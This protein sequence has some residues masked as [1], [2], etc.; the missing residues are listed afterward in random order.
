MKAV[1]F[2][3]TGD[4]RCDNIPIPCVGDDDVLIKV[5]YAGIC[6]SDKHIF[7]KGMFVEHIP[8]TMGHEFV[9]KVEKIGRNVTDFSIGN[10]VTANPMIY[11]GKCYACRQKMYNACETLTFIGES[12]PGGFAEYISLNKEKVIKIP[13]NLSLKTAVLCEPLAVAIHTLKRIQIDNRKKIAILGAGPIGILLAT[14]ASSIYGIRNISVIDISTNRLDFLKNKYPFICTKV[15]FA[16]QDFYDLIIDAA[17]SDVA[18]NNAIEHIYPD[19]SL[20]IVSLSEKRY[21]IDINLLV[22]RQIKLIGCNGYDNIDLVNALKYLSEKKV[23][24]D[25]MVSNE[26]SFDECKTAFA[27]LMQTEKLVLKIIFKN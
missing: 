6:G 5:A 20:C 10:Y 25:F 14:V 22:N 16:K 15:K 1:R 4:V 18:F 8:E 12:R 7:N 13:E 11:C 27:L 17:G 9:G 23:L 24:I 3:G 21:S 19:G 26:F 2:Y